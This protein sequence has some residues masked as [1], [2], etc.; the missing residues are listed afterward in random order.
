MEVDWDFCICSRSGYIQD[1]DETE[2]ALMQQSKCMIGL[3]EL[4]SLS[5]EVL[6]SESNTS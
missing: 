6:I 4:T 3:S 5:L 1:E 2:R